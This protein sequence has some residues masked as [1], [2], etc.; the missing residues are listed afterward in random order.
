MR[1][2][3]K[4]II[5]LSLILCNIFICCSCGNAKMTAEQQELAE[6]NANYA[7]AMVK[8]HY[9]ITGDDLT[10]DGDSIENGI[11]LD[12]YPEGTTFVE[13][14]STVK[15]NKVTNNYHNQIAVRDGKMQWNVA[16]KGT[17][18]Y[19]TIVDSLDTSST[20]NSD[21]PTSTYSSNDEDEGG[22][23]DDELNNTLRWYLKKTNFESSDKKHTL[24]VDVGE[25]DLSFIMDGQ[26]L[27]GV[28]ETNEFEMLTDYIKYTIHDN[29]GDFTVRYYPNEENIEIIDN[30]ND[31]TD[32]SGIYEYKNK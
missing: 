12:P 25:Y 27:A 18:K 4:N 30:V 2:C 13:F 29:N 19:K 16:V 15:S 7:L 1:I 28:V 21:T 31:K 32:Y 14:D 3:I 11:L 24:K 20:Y 23:V 17:D 5:S 6:S 26:F 10:I 22:D 8:I 9:S